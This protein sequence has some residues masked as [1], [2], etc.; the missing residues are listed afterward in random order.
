MKHPNNF[1]A[2]I[3]IMMCQLKTKMANHFV[4]KQ[5]NLIDGK[6]IVKVCLTENHKKIV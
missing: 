1:A 3:V 4:V 5:K 2:L 6:H